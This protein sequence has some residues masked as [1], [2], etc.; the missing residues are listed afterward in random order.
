MRSNC[1]IW[2]H[3]RYLNALLAWRRSGAVP[4]HHPKR[5]GIPSVHAPWWVM[6]HEVRT[7]DGKQFIV[8]AFV[9]IDKSVV[10]GWRVFFEIIFK[11]EV[12]RR[13]AGPGD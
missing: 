4:G 6:H 8:E 5:I 9:P 3:W 7:W 2:A 12:E 1:L 10:S 11:G 13:I